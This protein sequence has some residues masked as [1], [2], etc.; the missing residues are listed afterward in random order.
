[1]SQTIA[2]SAPPPRRLPCTMATVIF[3]DFDVS[4]EDGSCRGFAVTQD[5][6]SVKHEQ[7]RDQ[8]FEAIRAHCRETEHKVDVIFER[9]STW[10]AH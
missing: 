3:C 1:M 4:E 8:A 2:N 5:D 9:V 6:G 7:T 10:V